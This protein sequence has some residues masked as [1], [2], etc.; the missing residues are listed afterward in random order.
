M[1]GKTGMGAFVQSD[2][3]KSLN[4]GFCLDE[5]LANPTDA[6]TVFYGERSAW[7][8]LLKLST[9]HAYSSHLHLKGSPSLVLAVL[10]MAQD[11]SR[12]QLQKKWLVL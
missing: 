3:F 2:L 11:L 1:G 4:V 9:H 12:I 7:C 5:G 8:K 10:V 6:F